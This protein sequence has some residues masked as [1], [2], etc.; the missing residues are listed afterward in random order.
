MTSLVDNTLSKIAH[1]KTTLSISH[2]RGKVMCIYRERLSSSPHNNVVTVLL[3]SL[4][5][6]IFPEP[7]A[8]LSRNSS[9]GQRTGSR[10]HKDTLETFHY[11]K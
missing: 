11:P 3:L 7:A 1:L 4:P 2:L 10:L 5:V 9:M 8:H 6:D